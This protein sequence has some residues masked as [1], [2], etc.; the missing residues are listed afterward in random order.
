MV[1]PEG[2]DSVVVML[3]CRKTPTRA[4]WI[5][6]WTSSG[7]PYL[8][9]PGEIFWSPAS[10]GMSPARIERMRAEARAAN[11]WIMDS[12]FD[13]AGR[14]SQDLSPPKPEARFF[15]LFSMVCGRYWLTLLLSPI[16]LNRGRRPILA[17]ANQRTYALNR[18]AAFEGEG[19]CPGA[20]RPMQ[21]GDG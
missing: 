8:G 15:G 16:W 3:R 19:W 14:P 7:A 18:S 1:F 20:L 12:Y 10:S 11:G 17:A 6:T 21:S 2:A 5:R 13:A 4:L 9:M